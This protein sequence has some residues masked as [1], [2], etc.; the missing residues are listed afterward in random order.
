MAQAL[1]G[2]FLGRR[3]YQPTFELMQQ[4]FAARR[5]GLVG[6]LALFLEHPAVITLGR[7]ARPLVARPGR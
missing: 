3:K 7:G 5:Q 2:F 6:D 1:T 4:L